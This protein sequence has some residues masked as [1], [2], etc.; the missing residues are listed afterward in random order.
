MSHAS[1]TAINRGC[2]YAFLIGLVIV[3]FIFKEINGKL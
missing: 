3:A 2:F 1:H